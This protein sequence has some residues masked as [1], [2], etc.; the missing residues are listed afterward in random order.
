MRNL[1]VIH[2]SYTKL[3]GVN[4]LQLNHIELATE[5][6]EEKNEKIIADKDAA[7]AAEV[8]K[9]VALQAEI[10]RLKNK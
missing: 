1:P 4:M 8:A 7:I 9:N 6:D 5:D 2:V 10:D 3:I